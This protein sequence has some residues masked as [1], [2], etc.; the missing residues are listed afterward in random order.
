[1]SF[2]EAA[3]DVSALNREAAHKPVKVS[4]HCYAVIRYGQELAAASGGVFD[5]TVAAQLVGWGFLPHPDGCPAP[6][7]LACWR[8]IELM[9][10]GRIRFHRPLWIDLGG[11]AK[12]YAVDRAV[13]K[14][15]SLGVPQCRVNA[16]GDLRVAGPSSE[17]VVLRTA[18][19]G[20][21]VPVL[22]VENG[23]IASSSGREHLKR[24]EGREVGPHLHGLQKCAVGTHSFVSVVAEDCIA[25]DALT[26]VVLVGGA[27]FEHLLR[28]RGAIAYLH[29]AD[30][31]WRTIGGGAK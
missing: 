31:G 27:E 12:G 8:D 16:G 23:S 10:E 2:H 1:M 30:G 17:R 24:H 26:K 7:P 25:A 21:T 13:E 29:D 4:H 6:D 9:D 14:L 28:A 11:I 15:T 3:S 18:A 19:P 22:E 5:I 20:D